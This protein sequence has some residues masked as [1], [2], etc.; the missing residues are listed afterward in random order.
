M[1]L[2]PN[3]LNQALDQLPQLLLNLGQL[4]QDRRDEQ[5]RREIQQASQDFKREML[6]KR[7]KA[8]EV[9]KGALEQMRQVTGGADPPEVA[10]LGRR[11]EKDL[12]ILRGLGALDTPYYDEGDINVIKERAARTKSEIERVSGREYYVDPALIRIPPK[13]GIT[14]IDA[15]ITAPPTKTESEIELEKLTASK[16][17]D[18][19]WMARIARAEARIA[20]EK[21][22]PPAPAEAAVVEPAAA[23]PEG[24]RSVLTDK[25]WIYTLD[26]KVWISA[27]TGEPI[28]G[29]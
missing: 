6:T 7:I 20:G 3:T 22:P 5:L 15:A 19:A 14:T 17:T 26:E 16:R 2:P 9:K 25:G 1:P 8:E 18:P 24:A 27:E 21:A 10:I 29:Q 28:T 4:Q 12:D 11:I 23:I 13:E